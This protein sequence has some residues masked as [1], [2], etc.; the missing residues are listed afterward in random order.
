MRARKK[1]YI[2]NVGSTAGFL[3]GP[4][5]ATYYAT[6]NFVN[7]WSQALH[8]ELLSDGVVVSVVAPG[9]TATEFAQVANVEKSRLFQAGVASSAHVAEEGWRKMRRGQAV[10]VTGLKNRILVFSMRFAPR[11]ILLKIASFLNRDV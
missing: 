9:A 3:A 10:I 5:M 1:G 4:Y 2:L 7:S 8:E 11:W 6:K